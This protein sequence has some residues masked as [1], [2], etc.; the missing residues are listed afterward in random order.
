MKIWET[1]SETV[2]AGQDPVVV[3][4]TKMLA[5]VVKP[6]PPKRR[7]VE[8]KKRIAFSLYGKI[9]MAGRKTDIQ[10]C[11][12]P[13]CRKRIT[14]RFVCND[15]CRALAVEHLETALNLLAPREPLLPVVDEEIADVPIFDEQGRDR[16]AAEGDPA[17]GKGRGASGRRPKGYRGPKANVRRRKDLASELSR[18]RGEGD[19]S[20]RP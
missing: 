2:K 20:R 19:P 9:P 10:R 11:W 17:E 5:A 8:P 7:G 14:G 12:N 6:E 1:I 15:G 4:S 13:Y 18:A 3:L 16:R